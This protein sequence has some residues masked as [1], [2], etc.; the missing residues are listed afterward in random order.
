MIMKTME[1]NKIMILFIERLIIII[2]H[3]LIIPITHVQQQ[4]FVQFSSF[5]GSAR[6]L[7]HR[8]RLSLK[9]C[10]IVAESRYSSS[11][12]PSRSAIA[13]SN[14]A[15]ASLHAWSGEFKIS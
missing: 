3:I 2:E 10:I 5:V 15:L 8:V 4:S 6:S 1:K 9:S 14:A 13:L 11:S 12:K 7:V